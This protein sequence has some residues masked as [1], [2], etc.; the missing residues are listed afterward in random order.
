MDY[1]YGVL[2][3]PSQDEAEL[4]V[5]PEDSAFEL[6]E[7]RDLLRCR[8]W[9]ELRAKAS[10]ERYRE[11]LTKC[12]YGEFAELSAELDPGGGVRGALE[13]ALAE[14]DPRAVP[15]GDGEPFH[16]RDLAAGPG[17]GY[18]PDPHYLQNR[19]VSA[20]I[21]DRWG[22]RYETPHRLPC[23]VLRASDLKAVITSLEAEGHNCREDSDLIRAGVEE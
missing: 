9:G 20:Q 19:L 11:L 12:G 23:A 7:I 8:T 22:E 6:A 13:M 3:D 14:F 15:P 10:P 18:P 21:V 4:V 5:L 16:A 17:E 2:T 1:V